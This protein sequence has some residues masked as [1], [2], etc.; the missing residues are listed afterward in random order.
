M[1]ATVSTTTATG[2]ESQDRVFSW[3][4]RILLSVISW[5]AA[6]ALRVIGPTL[7]YRASFEAGGPPTEVIHPAIYVFWHRCV[8]VAT[9][10]FRNRGIAVM[11]SRSFDGEYITRIIQRFGFSAVRGSSS[12]GAVRALLG[13]HKVVERGQAVAFTVD[14]PRGP[15]YVAKPGPVLLARHTGVPVIAFH[16]AVEKAWVLNSWDRFM[17]P[18]PFSRV[19]LRFS[20]MMQVPRDADNES[21]ARYHAEMQAALGRVRDFADANVSLEA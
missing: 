6:L 3:R 13:M 7:R 10:Y 19:L 21:T 16:L 2:A 17:I 12:R 9:Y 5:A 8:F 15:C 1:N 4:Q 18:K 11:T 14:G 20:T